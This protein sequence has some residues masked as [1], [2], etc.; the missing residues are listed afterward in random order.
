MTGTELLLALKLQL[1]QLDTGSNKT[2]Y[3]EVGLDFLDK[4]Y[5]VIVRSKYSADAPEDDYFGKNQKVD[6]ELNHLIKPLPFSGNGPLFKL[7]I[8]DITGYFFYLDTDNLRTGGLNVHELRIKPVGKISTA[9]QDPFNRPEKLYP[10]VSMYDNSIVYEID[11]T[12]DIEGTLMYL[13]LPELIT[14]NDECIA[15]FTDEIVDTAAVM[16]LESWKDERVQS[17]LPVD[18]ALKNN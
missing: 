2:L 4:A 3:T 8:S 5:K 11:D 12:S 7:P 6:D 9:S 10:T 1:N 17:K 16:I 14:L 13:G 18:Q 15:P